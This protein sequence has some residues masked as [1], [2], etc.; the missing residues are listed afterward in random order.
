M[1]KHSD[2]RRVGKGR[3]GEHRDRPLRRMEG[4]F[5]LGESRRGCDAL[6]V[7]REDLLA[8][9]REINARNYGPRVVFAGT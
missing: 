9:R 6:S 7:R 4:F 2:V 5:D 1:R 8:M 3:V